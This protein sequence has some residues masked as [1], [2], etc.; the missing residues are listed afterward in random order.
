MEFARRGI[1]ATINED[2]CDFRA[3]VSDLLEEK[4]RNNVKLQTMLNFTRLTP[5][6]FV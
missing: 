6:T 3:E 5:D 1:P 4:F 2:F